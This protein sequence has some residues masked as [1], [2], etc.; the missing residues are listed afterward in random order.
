MARLRS[1]PVGAVLSCWW[2]CHSL[3][4]GD[5]TVTSDLDAYE[6]LADDNNGFPHQ[7]F[8]SSDIK[9]PVFHINHWDKNL[10]DDTPYIFIGTNYGKIGAGA[11]PMIID[12]SDLSLVYADQS[13]TNNYHSEMQTIHDKPHLTYW[14]KDRDLGGVHVVV[15]ENYNKKYNATAVSPHYE[16]M[17]EF[18]VTNE[19]TAVFTTHHRIDFDC[20][21]WGGSSSCHVHDTGFQEVDLETNEV[22]FG[23]WAADHFDPADSY[24]RFVAGDFGLNSER[25][26]NYDLSHMNGTEDGNYL[27]SS[28]H[29]FS[30]QLIDGKTGEPIWTLGGKKNSFTDLSNGSATNIG[31]QHNARFYHNHSQI[32]LFDNHN[33]NQG[34]CGDHCETR[35]LH[36]EIDTKEMTARVIREYYHPGHLDSGAMGGMQ[37]LDSGNAIVGW[38]WTPS[39]VEYASDGQVAMDIQRGKVGIGRQGNMFMYRVNK[40]H[41]TG[42]PT[43]PPSF[44]VDEDDGNATIYM[45]WNGATDIV[46]WF[47]FSSEQ[48]DKVNDI[49]HL[50][51]APRTGFE[52]SA[53]IKADELSRFVRVAAVDKA[54]SV[55]GVSDVFDR[56]A[57]Y[58]DDVASG[59][60][61]GRIKI[62]SLAIG[63]IFAILLITFSTA[64]GLLIYRRRR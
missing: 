49:E 40:G 12:A 50:F 26:G 34:D 35:G 51:T 48:S 25:E 41:W 21:L 3:V 31:W 16:D 58:T 19:G 57:E 42:R 7:T 53:S 38:G 10:T 44:V 45:S 47:I 5:F 46:K 36:V 22:L 2:L 4:A 9:G 61:D 37:L 13:Y 28:R 64:F 39:I 18:H 43:W 14:A 15:D 11:G 20:S 27:I 8:R 6:K 60:A 52:T 29:F 32:T 56:Q 17:H 55:L 30:V 63:S 59:D 24:A 1:N 33:E 23:W 54:G 62:S